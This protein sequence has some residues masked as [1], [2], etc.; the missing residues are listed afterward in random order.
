MED[1]DDG[2]GRRCV[3]HGANVADGEEYRDA[4]GECEGSAKHGSSDYGAGD[5]NAG[6]HNFFAYVLMLVTWR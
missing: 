6:I 1:F 2:E 4:E 5:D 3:E